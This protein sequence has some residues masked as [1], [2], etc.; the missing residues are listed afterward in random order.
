MSKRATGA[1]AESVRIVDRHA[2]K[3]FAERAFRRSGLPGDDDRILGRA[4][5]VPHQ[6]VE[7]AAEFVDVS[8]ARLVAERD[9]KRV[10]G[11]V[12]LFGSGQDVS[13][14]LADVVHV[15][16]A[17]P[18]D[19]VQEPR[20]RELRGSHR[21]AGRDRHAP[22]RHQRIG[23]EERHRQVARVVGR[24][25]ELLHQVRTRHQHH[26][27]RYL[28]RL[29]ITAGAGGED[30]HVR[31]ERL[32]LAIRS[33]LTGGVKRARPVLAGH[34]D[35]LDVP[36]VDAVQQRAV[37]RVG[38][39]DLAVRPAHIGG[40]GRSTPRGVEPAEYIPAEACSCHL[41]EELRCI[42]HQHADVHRPVAVDQ[43]QQGRGACGR[44][45]KVLAPRP[46][47]VTVL[48]RNRV[49]RCTFSKQLLDGFTRHPLVLANSQ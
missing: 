40:Q 16:N 8:V 25:V 19:V 45:A 31:V 9:A 4:E 6:R 49:G 47:P 29:R 2:R 37:L 11:V 33:Q 10:V 34:V 44:L 12:R 1:I 26:E 36:E 43:R 48:H 41:V 18:S 15:R 28:H 46:P 20:R 22:A 24:D 3:A 5:T 17:V 30:Q 42:A 38:H 14:R 35:H 32:D 13:Q 27:V 7:P 23:M 39:H 21:R